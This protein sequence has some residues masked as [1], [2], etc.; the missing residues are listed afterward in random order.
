MLQTFSI[1]PKKK[2]YDERLKNTKKRNMKIL[3]QL[4]KCFNYYISSFSN[5][6]NLNLNKFSKILAMK[7]TV[8]E[9]RSTYFKQNFI[10]NLQNKNW[11]S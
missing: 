6:L 5:S 9:F 7:M 10:I 8:F 1:P 11:M 3:T 2:L 4:L